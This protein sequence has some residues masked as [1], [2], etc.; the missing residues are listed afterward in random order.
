MSKKEDDE[1]L[2]NLLIFKVYATNSEISQIAPWV[3][4]IS[5]VAGIILY[6]LS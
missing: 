2:K 1:R 5:V 3:L 4:I 6:F